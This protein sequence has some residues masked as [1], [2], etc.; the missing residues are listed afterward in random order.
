MPRQRHDGDRPETGTSRELLSSAL[1]HKLTT[2]R[3]GVKGRP[4][5]K[6]ER[7]TNMRQMI[8]EHIKELRRL[9]R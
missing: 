2:W 9:P 7:E 8:L 4:V 5:T 3:N 6:A 1:G